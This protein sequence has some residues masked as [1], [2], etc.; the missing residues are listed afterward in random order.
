MIKPQIHVKLPKG[1]SD[2]VFYNTYHKHLKKDI[3][4]QIDR[5]IDGQAFVVRS[6][7]GEWGEW[8]ET[9]ELKNGKPSIVKQGWS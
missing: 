3:K 2:V 1:V 8:T 9:W 6:K 4:A 5:S 7:R